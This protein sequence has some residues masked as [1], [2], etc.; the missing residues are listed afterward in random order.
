VND[1]GER[2]APDPETGRAALRRTWTDR[3][4]L[5]SVLVAAV[6]PL[7]FA[8]LSTAGAPLLAAVVA[9][10]IASVLG[11][12]Y[13]LVR[14]D[15]VRAAAIGLGIT[16]VCASVAAVT[17]EARGFFLLP[18]LVPF[19]VI[20]VCLVTMAV[21]R[22]LT[23]LILNRVSGGPPDWTFHPRIVRVHQ[24]ATGVAVLINMVNATVQVTFYTASDTV[25]LAVAHI[26]T[27]PA[28]ATLVA[29]TLV[30][31]RRAVRQER[32]TEVASA[33]ANR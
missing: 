30:A 12:A 2:L 9:A 1:T 16:V 15:G 7:L 27:G 25:V 20:A 19:L 10:V 3:R 28:F 24:V 22:P 17:G 8:V 6:P 23:G 5:E 32:A 29:V 26:A 13:R 14:R 11:A 21:R 4:R 31:A 33:A 18:A